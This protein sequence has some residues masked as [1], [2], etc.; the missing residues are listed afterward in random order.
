MR[1][2][3]PDLRPVISRNGRAADVG[4]GFGFVRASAKG[5]NAGA[6]G[7]GFISKNLNGVGGGGRGGEGCCLKVTSSV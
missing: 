5:A 6:R 7:G 3:L 2:P 4:D 1:P